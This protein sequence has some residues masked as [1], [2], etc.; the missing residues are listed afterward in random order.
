MLTIME[1]ES[2]LETGSTSSDAR[3][4]TH[5]Y[6]GVDDNDTSFPQKDRLFKKQLHWL[7]AKDKRVLAFLSTLSQ[8]RQCMPSI[9]DFVPYT[10]CG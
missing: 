7:A 1:H 9:L 3:S 2:N 6:D 10:Q 5:G 4:Q 8:N